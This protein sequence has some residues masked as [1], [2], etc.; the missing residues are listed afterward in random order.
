M[1]KILKVIGPQ[2]T[3]DRYFLSL[4]GKDYYKLFQFK[5]DAVED[6]ISEIEKKYKNFDLYN[7]EGQIN[8]EDLYI[9][10]RE[11]VALF[12]PKITRDIFG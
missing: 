5:P 7:D 2:W 1:K 8:R 6:I 10:I 3:V 11:K 4:E 9:G 12:S